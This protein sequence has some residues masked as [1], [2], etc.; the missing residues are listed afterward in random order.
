MA[1]TQNREAPINIRARLAQRTCQ[2]TTDEANPD[3]A[4]AFNHAALAPAR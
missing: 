1:E 3:N 2:R 4:Q